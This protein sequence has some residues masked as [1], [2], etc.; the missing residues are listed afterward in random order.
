MS[1]DQDVW[2][3]R[4]AEAEQPEIRVRFGQLPNQ[5]LPLEWAEQFLAIVYAEHPQVFVQILPRLYGLPEA[6]RR[7]RRPA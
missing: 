6:R 1:A 7:G 5:V 3:P 2:T 4:L